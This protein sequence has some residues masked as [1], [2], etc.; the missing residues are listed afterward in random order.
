V[1]L[2]MI[3]PKSTTSRPTLQRQCLGRL[4]QPLVLLAEPTTG[5]VPQSRSNLW[6][7]IRRLRRDVGTTVLLI[8]HCLDQAGALC[9]EPTRHLGASLQRA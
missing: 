3:V 1:A 8:S 7:H 4:Q 5:L 9:I 6:E 2:T